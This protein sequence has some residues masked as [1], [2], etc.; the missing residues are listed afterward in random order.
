MRLLSSKWVLKPQKPRRSSFLASVGS[1]KRR[2]G[3][4]GRAQAW[5][6][7]LSRV[8]AGRFGVGVVTDRVVFGV[9][10]QEKNFGTTTRRR[11]SFLPRMDALL[12]HDDV[13]LCLCASHLSCRDISS[14]ASAAPPVRC[15]RRTPPRAPSPSLSP[16]TDPRRG[17]AP[18][19]ST[20]HV[21]RSSAASKCR[22]PCSAPWSEE[23]FC[24]ARPDRRRS[25]GVD[26]T[27]MGSCCR[28]RPG[29]NRVRRLHHPLDR[30]VAHR[31]H[32]VDVVE[33]R[34]HGQLLVDAPAD[35]RHGGQ[36]GERGAL[37]PVTRP[38]AFDIS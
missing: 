3:R 33:V 25:R 17:A 13:V 16:A 22:R 34:P 12:S 18:A 19:P 6:F 28:D 5:V 27:P 37:D 30:D 10:T 26:G 4:I 23:D 1:R 15:S 38:H 21:A 8:A 14:L 7:S 32:G 24:A 2:R 35:Q 20:S 31:D 9:R 36:V 11:P 29:R